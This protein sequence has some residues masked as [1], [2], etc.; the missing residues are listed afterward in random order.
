M[1]HEFVEKKAKTKETFT[2]SFEGVNEWHKKPSGDGGC[3][4]L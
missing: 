2:T 4:I 1:I 3:V